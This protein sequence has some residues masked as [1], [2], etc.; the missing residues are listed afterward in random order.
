MVNYQI[1]LW[2]TG[3]SLHIV[4]PLVAAFV[5]SLIPDNDL[6]DE[7]MLMY[8][9]DV[10]VFTT[11]EHCTYLGVVLLLLLFGPA[12]TAFAY[13]V[14][15]FF[16]SGSLCNI[17]IIII[18]FLT[19]MVGPIASFTLRLIAKDPD[20]PWE[21][22][23][24]IAKLIEGI[25]LFF[26][27]FCM[28]KGL[29]YSMNI[30]AFEIQTSAK[31][32]VFDQ[33]ILLFEVIALPL[34]TI[35]YTMLAVC[36]DRF[37]TNPDVTL[38]CRIFKSFLKCNFATATYQECGTEDISDDDDVIA[39][40][41][42]IESNSATANA[43]AVRKISKVFSTGKVA[44]SNLS[45]G[46]C[47]GQC[48]GLLGSNGAGKT[49]TMSILTSEIL[50][51]TGSVVF[52]GQDISEMSVK[53]HVGFCPQFDAIFEG[54]T[55]R[56][57]LEFYAAIKGMHATQLKKQAEEVLSQVGI[58]SA[59]RDRLALHY[60][61]GQ[62]RKLSL[63]C[64]LIGNPSVVFFDEVTTGVDP[65]SRREIWNVISQLTNTTNA[66]T[67]KKPC[68]VLTTHSM[69]ECEA[70]CSRIGIMSRGRLICLGSAQRLKSK[71][72]HG[73]QI[74]LKVKQ[75]AE[76]DTDFAAICERLRSHQCSDIEATAPIEKMFFNIEQTHAALTAIS[77]DD[78]LSS[79]VTTGNFDAA[80]I[81][82]EAHSTDGVSLPIL[83][84]FV[85]S[86]LRMQN[87]DRFVSTTWGGVRRERQ[88]MKVRYE[89][90]SSDSNLRDIFSDIEENK[91]KLWLSEYSVNQTSLEQVFNTLIAN[92]SEQLPAK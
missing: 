57:Q 1:P 47:S 43:V 84:I 52:D 18:G 13:C 48:F 71:F 58:G 81:F 26:P 34:Q 16:T 46:I 40:E 11:S 22:L 65:G 61:G 23:V 37:Q 76:S 45:L 3:E 56:E 54:L 64:A 72:G 79:M 86:Q 88:D 32:S 90:S 20:N 4:V 63:A 74:E 91:D 33:Q 10:D 59:D 87:L 17:F 62:K 25:G 68:A 77:G 75:I 7:V 6:F 83:A 30:S 60:S 42:R 80:N 21:R 9:L 85:A 89:I 38:F 69:E 15:F 14:S 53:P 51:T 70:L 24:R 27:S 39:E 31:L 44:V 19:G 8:V 66:A 78:S 12:A 28:G 92:D 73:Y 29:F 50:P 49:T 2:F 5:P 41:E 55:G 35:A 67:G 82:N 36:L